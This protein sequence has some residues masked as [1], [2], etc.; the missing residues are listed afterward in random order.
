MR[1]AGPERRPEHGHDR[2]AGARDII[3]FAQLPPARMDGAVLLDQNHSLLPERSQYAAKAAAV[4]QARAA[5][6][7]SFSLATGM[8]VA[9][10]NSRRFG[11][12]RSAPR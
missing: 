11:F 12:N 3:D 7:T 2:V 4:D 5:A 10:A 1:H 8:P 6:I 9:C